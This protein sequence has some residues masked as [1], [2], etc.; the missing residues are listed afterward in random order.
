MNV[1]V[2]DQSKTLTIG[3]EDVALSELPDV[4]NLTKIAEYA[5]AVAEQYP[6]ERGSKTF[7]NA[8][9]AYV[10]HIDFA[11]VH[12]KKVVSSHMAMNGVRV[13]RGSQGQTIRG[14][15][16]LAVRFYNTLSAGAVRDY[17]AALNIDHDA[18]ETVDERFTAMAQA[19][20]PE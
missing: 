16:S 11:G 4:H 3:D 9:S 10:K 15:R 5:N 17:C 19:Q 1:A 13:K 2:D 7:V 6:D 18:Y 20:H 12:W 8:V 14:K